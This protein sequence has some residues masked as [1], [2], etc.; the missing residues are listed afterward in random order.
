MFKLGTFRRHDGST[1]PGIVVADRVIDV[2]SAREL[3]PAGRAGI[4]YNSSIY[5]LLQD[6]DRWF[7]ALTQIADRALAE[8][9]DSDRIRP[10]L[11]SMDKLSIRPP[12]LRP[13]KILNAAANYSGHLAEMRSYTQTGD[14]PPQKIFAGDKKN[15]APYL[16]L[17]ASSALTG[18]FDPIELP[19]G[20]HQ[21]DWEVE[22]AVGIGK[23]GKRIKAERAVDH[24]AGFMTFND[25]SCRTR[26]WREDRPNFRT[27][28]L[29]SKSYDTFAPLGPFFVPRQ[30]VPDHTTLRIS[31]KVNGQ[32]MQQGLAG[33]MIYSA[34]EQIE[35]ASAFMTL[36]PGDIFATGTIAGVGQGKGTFLKRGDLVEA[37]VEGLGAQRNPVI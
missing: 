8:G 6:W 18:A 20:D 26:L 22:L 34:E 24:M 21:T 27:D 12:I 32:I 23:A 31:L 9:Y 3:L 4:H 36:E 15:A 7:E 13:G 29:T 5:D 30:F 37:E 19:E 17:K 2:V 35:Y 14:V 11:A 1:F 25:V 10:M 28:W 33:D 16:F